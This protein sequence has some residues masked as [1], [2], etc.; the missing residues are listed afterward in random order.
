M[1]FKKQKCE[2][3]RGNYLNDDIE[4]IFIMIVTTVT[5]TSDVGRKESSDG[6]LK[7]G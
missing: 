2:W 6:L 7:G 4:I 5:Y 1:E 3:N